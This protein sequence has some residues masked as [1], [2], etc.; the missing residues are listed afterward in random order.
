VT[1]RLVPYDPDWPAAYERA[2][3]ET[4]EALGTA[5]ILGFEH[6]GST[7]IP[8]TCAKPVIDMQVGVEELG[9]V[10]KWLEAIFALGYLP[11]YGSPGRRTFERRRADGTASHHLHFV[12]YGSPDWTHPLLFRDWLRTHPSDR[13]AYERLKRELAA[14]HEDTRTYSEAKTEFVRGIQARARP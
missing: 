14:A 5:E 1:I 10:E 4:L 7:S 8:G 13:D 9:R 3:A 2:R 12:V 11:W 6:I